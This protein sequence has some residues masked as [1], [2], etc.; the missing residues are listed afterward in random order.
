MATHNLKCWPEFYV[1][2][3]SGRKTFEVRKDDRGFKVGDVL[4]LECWDPVAKDYTGDFFPVRVNY[5]LPGG[6]FGVL[7]GFVVMSIELI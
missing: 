3:R 4:I 5:I 7:P 1:E 6:S 2:V